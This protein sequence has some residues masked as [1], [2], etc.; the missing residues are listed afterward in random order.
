MFSFE[1]NFQVPSFTHVRLAQRIALF[2]PFAP[3]PV[4]DL[5]RTYLVYGIRFEGLVVYLLIVKINYWN[6]LNQPLARKM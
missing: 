2:F 4:T 6:G 5:E 1:F 3:K